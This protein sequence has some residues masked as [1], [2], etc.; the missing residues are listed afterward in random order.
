[1]TNNPGAVL[2]LAAD[3]DLREQV[4]R[5][6]AAAGLRAVPAC[7]PPTRKAWQAAIA[8][9]LDEE[10][11]RE[12]ARDG[13]PRR[14]G[15]I[16]ICPAEP[17]SSTWA[18]AMA[19]GARHVCA[20]PAHDGELVRH[21]ADAA[22]AA[23][24]GPRAGRVIAVTG[25]RGGAGASTFATALALVASGSLLI[26]LD[27]WGGGIDLLAGTES[28]PGLRWPDLSLQGGRLAW[29]AVRNALPNHQGV[30]VLSG[31]R[32]GHQ[33]DA[34][35]VDA[36]IDAGRRGG[37]LVICDLPRRMTSAATATLDGSDLVVLIATCDVRGVAAASAMAPELRDINPNIGLVMRG[38]APG[39]LRAVEAAKAV[40]LPLLAAMR[41]E[42]MLAERLEHSG[43]RLR[44]RSPLGAGART[45]LTLLPPATQVRTA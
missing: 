43:L 13:L 34:G 45:V 9:L 12:C 11:A 44:R 3:A 16:L 23:L 17:E 25:G 21:L 27:P 22:D 41:P 36:V 6:A 40:G 4:D 39:G 2:T 14:E 28:A 20:V 5:V 8:I 35:A 29:A 38:P 26:D 30:S 10:S 1:V 7:A 37:A 24:E 42:P 19:I 18:A 32:H 15:V 33:L 31:A